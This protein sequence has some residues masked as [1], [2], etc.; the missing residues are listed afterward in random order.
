[1]KMAIREGQKGFSP[2]KQK[3]GRYWLK[4]VENWMCCTGFK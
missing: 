4:G 3:A 1:M 2:V